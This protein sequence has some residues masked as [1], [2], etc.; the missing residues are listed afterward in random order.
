MDNPTTWK[1]NETPKS[2][3]NP[4]TEVI[5]IEYFNDLNETIKST[6]PSRQLMTLPT[7][8]ADLY[9]RRILDAVVNHRKIKHVDDNVKAELLKEIVI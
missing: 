5:D 1:P 7:H 3:F 4:L 6:I 8:L 2:F 9:I